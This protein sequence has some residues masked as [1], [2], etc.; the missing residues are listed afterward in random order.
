MPAGAWEDDMRLAGVVAL[1]TGG[2]LLWAVRCEAVDVNGSARVYGGPVVV[3]DEDNQQLDQR[4]Q[5]NLVQELTPYLQLIAAYRHTQFENSPEEGD[6][7]KRR[8]QEPDLQLLYDRPQFTARLSYRERATRSTNEQEELD[9]DSIIGQLQWRPNSGPRFSL[10]I[11]D[12]SNV[13]DV[14]VFGRDTDSRVVELGLLYDRRT[15]SA[16]YSYNATDVD[17]NRT[18]LSIDENRHDL[19]ATYSDRYLGDRLFFSADG[20]LSLVDQTEES[21]GSEPFGQVVPAREGLF[22]VNTSPETAELAPSPDLID[23][24]LETPVAP[25]IEI[26]GASTFRNIGV[27]LGVTRQVSQLEIFVDLPSSNLLWEIY[28]SPDNLNWQLVLGTLS[29][30]DSGFLRY[31][32]R[33]PE[34]TNRYFKAVNVGLNANPQVAVTEIRAL[35]DVDQIGR[36]EGE[37]TTYR[38]NVRGTYAPTERVDFTVLASTRNDENISG[39]LISRDL[40]ELSYSGQ[41]RVDVSS[42]LELG[43]RYRFD[44]LEE[45]QEPVLKREEEQFSLNL[46]WSPLPTLQTRLSASR[47]DE[48]DGTTLLRSSDT[49][50]LRLLTDLLTDLRLVSEVSFTATEDPFSGFEQTSWRF[51]ETLDSRPTE[52]LLVSAYAAY[53]TFDSNSDALIQERLNLQLRTTWRA[54]PYLSLTG[55]WDFSD[56]DLQDTFSQ[57]YSL[58][59]NPGRKLSASASYRD[60]DSRDVRTETSG[61]AVTYRMNRWLTPYLTFNR[62][63]FEQTALDPTVTRTARLGFNLFF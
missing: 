10:R 26:G 63:A 29:E 21:A 19:R 23:G 54:T 34:T 32:L 11:R 45:K 22:A 43:I 39:G 61:I 33:F 24:D 55:D 51:S 35:V 5:V 2:L 53:Q 20:W 16:R 41:V 42:E 62:S 44:D 47:R 59:W 48:S 27:D 3:D 9:I 49:V 46:D 1:L 50:R 37:A 31:T 6:V 60:T 56:T 25:R 7:F 28:E 18:G 13:A 15:W 8:S 40:D 12:D 36:T 17:N 30:F 52:R 14:A 58:S 38:L 4:Y 57:L